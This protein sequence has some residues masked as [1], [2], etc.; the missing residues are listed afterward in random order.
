MVKF[1]SPGFLRPEPNA[2]W[3]DLLERFEPGS[4][5]PDCCVL[6]T[7]RSRHCNLCNGCVDRF[8]HHCPWVNNCIGRKNFKWFYSFLVVQIL[9]L[10]SVIIACFWYLSIYCFSVDEEYKWL[11]RDVTYPDL[12][13]AASFIYILISFLFAASVM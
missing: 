12:R 7:P 3:V 4:L 1:S 8:D 10:I 13:S 11:M 5:C 9:Y 6:K 2:D